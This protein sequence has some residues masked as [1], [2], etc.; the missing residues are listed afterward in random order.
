MRA[1]RIAFRFQHV[2]PNPGEILAEEN[3]GQA[4]SVVQKTERLGMPGTRKH[5]VLV[6]NHYFGERP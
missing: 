6:T 3:F 1:I 4:F 2:A 5:F